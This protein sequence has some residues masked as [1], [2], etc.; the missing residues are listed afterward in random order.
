MRA[1]AVIVVGLIVAGFVIRDA[2]G[3]HLDNCRRNAWVQATT[4]D[5]GLELYRGC[6]RW[7]W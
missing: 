7:P 1:L 2:G 5:R 6:S 4:S 3:V